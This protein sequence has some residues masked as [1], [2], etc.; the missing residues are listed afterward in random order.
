[1][2]DIDFERLADLTEF[3]VSSDI[4]LLATEA[5]RDALVNNLEYIDQ[6][7]LERTIKNSNPSVIEDE[8]EYYKQFAHMERK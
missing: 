8:I 7:T 6:D 3:Y 5:A 4:E 1:M 2:E